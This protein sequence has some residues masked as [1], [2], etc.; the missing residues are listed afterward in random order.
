MTI[1]TV[2]PHTVESMY[3]S[4]VSHEQDVDHARRAIEKERAAEQAHLDALTARDAAVNDALTTKPDDL[5]DN[6]LAR[7]LGLKVSTFR[8]ITQ[9]ARKRR[10]ARDA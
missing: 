2:H 3:G 7:R 9:E 1:T 6:E 10:R 5:S 4:P 8:S